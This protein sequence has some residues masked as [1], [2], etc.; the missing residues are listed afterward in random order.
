[1]AGSVRIGGARVDI[2]GQDADFQRTMRR[3]GQQFRMMERRLERTRREAKKTTSAFQAMK[4]PLAALAS[5]AGVGAL[6]SL[7]R[8]LGEATREA[9]S[10]GATLVEIAKGSG[11]T[12]EALQAIRYAFEGQGIE[13]QKADRALGRLFKT[14]GEAPDL[15][16]YARAFENIGVNWQELH[17][18]GADVQDVLFEV[19]DAFKRSGLTATTAASASQLLGRDWQQ[20]IVAV[21]GGRQAFIDAREELIRLGALMTNETAVTLKSLDQDFLNLEKRL[22]NQMREA[23]VQHADD[24]VRATSAWN[25]FKIAIARGASAAVGFGEDAA[26][27]GRESRRLVI[28][29]QLAA[30]YRAEEQHLRS[31]ARRQ[32]TIRRTQKYNADRPEAYV[33]NLVAPEREAILRRRADIANL[34]AHRA[35][36]RAI[37]KGL[38]VDYEGYLD[39]FR[40]LAARMRGG[41]FAEISDYGQDPAAGVRAGIREGR[42]RDALRDWAREQAQADREA[43]D[44]AMAAAEHR[45]AFVEDFNR[46]MARIRREQE[47]TLY[48]IR[49]DRLAAEEKDEA[50]AL[51]K[52]VEAYRRRADASRRAAEEAREQWLSVGETLSSSL[53]NAFAGFITG[54]HSAQDAFR[55]LANSI[56]AEIARIAIAQKAAN[57]IL[58]LFQLGGAFG[59]SPFGPHGFGSGAPGTGRV[60][61]GFG[62][63]RRLGGP[64]AAGQAYM[65][66]ES[67][68][69]LF[70]PSERGYVHRSGT[71]GGVSVTFAGPLVGSIQS[72]DG[73]GVR[74]ALAEAAPAISQSAAEAVLRGLKQP[75]STRKTVLGY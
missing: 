52:T 60:P 48:K 26:E 58:S 33:E 24:V 3:A 47:G 72:S 71:G 15:V 22:K 31:I 67:G 42:D 45:R 50:E 7:P 75:G 28:A 61:I 55:S 14:F 21:G 57:A 34:K 40:R 63:G 6:G 17:A 70:V 73:P 16:T 49:A 64:V 56:I 38:L 30:T 43:N 74:R 59:G 13:T 65:V 37:Y 32:E 20:L 69:E 39:S 66:G 18:R 25:E 9:T 10:F 4:G 27:F 62:G 23:L 53:G 5:F 1:M 8:Q 54:T 35:S 36:L 29:R 11:V 51:A 46:E 19:A 68:P 41:L 44:A 2:S 12:V